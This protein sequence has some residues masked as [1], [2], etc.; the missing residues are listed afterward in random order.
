M[1]YHFVLE[2]GSYGIQG[3]VG[4]EAKP[5][6]HFESLG[7]RTRQPDKLALATPAYRVR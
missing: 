6:D 4:P 5:H 7:L 3:G 1:G 2:H